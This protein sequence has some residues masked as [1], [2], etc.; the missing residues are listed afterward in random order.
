MSEEKVGKVRIKSL[1]MTAGRRYGWDPKTPGVGINYNL[2]RNNDRIEI[3]Y[4]KATY[5]IDSADVRKIAK[6]HQSYY[7]LPQGIILYVIPI[8]SCKIVTQKLNL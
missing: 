5:Y 6:K 2:I 7:F 4:Q 1:F 3:E 8:S